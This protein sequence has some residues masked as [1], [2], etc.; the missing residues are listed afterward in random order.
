M[1]L[2][3]ERAKWSGSIL[4]S[5]PQRCAQAARASLT[6]SALIHAL[7]IRSLMALPVLPIPWAGWWGHFRVPPLPVP[8]PADPPPQVDW[9]PPSSRLRRSA[10]AP[11]PRKPLPTAL[12]YPPLTLVWCL[13]RAASTHLRLSMAVLAVGEGG[14]GRGGVGGE[15]RAPAAPLAADRAPARRVLWARRFCARQA[16]FRLWV[17]VRGPCAR[18]RPRDTAR[19][20]GIGRGVVT[21][22]GVAAETARDVFCGR[23]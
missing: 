15:R 12:C 14:G 7:T 4:S 10:A 21:G 13:S 5:T 17:H 8:P 11:S 1:N 16:G 2:P 19:A 18:K 3:S 6:S 20:C 9:P 23:P 22:R